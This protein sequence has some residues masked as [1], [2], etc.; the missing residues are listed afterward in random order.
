MSFTSK[1]IQSRKNSM[2]FLKWATL[3]F[4]WMSCILLVTKAFE[5]SPSTTNAIQYI[6]TI[7]LTNDGSN[8]SGTGIMLEWSWGDGRFRNSVTVNNLANTIVIGTNASGKLISSTSGAVYNYIS[9]Y[10]SSTSWYWIAI[11]DGTYTWIQY[12]WGHIVTNGFISKGYGASASGNYA[13]AMWVDTR[14]NG[15]TSTAMG[16]ETNASGNFSTAMWVGTKAMGYASTAMWAET[17]ANGNYSTAMWQSTIANGTHSIAIGDTTFVS[18]KAWFVWGKWNTLYGDYGFI[19]WWGG[20]IIYTWSHYS[21]VVGGQNNIIHTNSSW[22]SIGWWYANRLLWEYNTIAW[23]FSNSITWASVDK[24]NFIGGWYSNNMENSDLSSIVWWEDNYIKNWYYGFIGWWSENSIT[25]WR[26]F[27]NSIVWWTKNSI[28]GNTSNN[29]IAWGLTNYIS[30]WTWD[31]FIGGWLSNYINAGSD[32]FIGWGANNSITDASKSFIG[33]GSN[34]SITGQYNNVLVGWFSNHI[35]WAYSSILWWTNNSISWDNSVA[36]WTYAQANHDN[37]FV[38][39]DSSA[40]F[41]SLTS[42]TFLVHAKNGIGFSTTTENHIDIATWVTVQIDS[43]LS[44]KRRDSDYPPFSCDVSHEGSMYF[45]NDE[46]ATLSGSS[47]VCI[48]QK[49]E[50]SPYTLGRM[51]ISSNNPEAGSCEVEQFD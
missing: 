18:G 47:Y 31:G 35:I 42:N 43:V 25:W 10:I 28:F 14:A 36:M 4:L 49:Q 20:N 38:W 16:M 34:N 5:I 21:F 39:N 7:F 46:N 6:K 29:T 27:S 48:C 19:G 23:W 33:W 40:I 22:S 9:G 50:A 12:T 30:N 24:D 1:N 13:T 3:F 45:Y 32:S 11:A 37:T 2:G 41:S 17:N 8:T 26:V 51:R 44:L 15:D